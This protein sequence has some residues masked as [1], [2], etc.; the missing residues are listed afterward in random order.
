MSDAAV[1]ENEKEPGYLEQLSDDDLRA[2]PANVIF[3]LREL[4]GWLAYESDTT[5]EG[6]SREIRDMLEKHHEL[7]ILDGERAR[8]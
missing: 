4:G 8:R 5:A 7:L 6:Y 1:K 2:L 3:F